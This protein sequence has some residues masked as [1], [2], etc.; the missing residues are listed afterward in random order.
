MAMTL[1]A[2][3]AAGVIGMQR[4]TIQ[5][6][7][8][9]RRFDM[10]TQ[11]RQRVGRA[12]PARRGVLDPAEL[13]EPE[14][15]RPQQD[16]LAQERRHVRRDFCN[17]PMPAAPA[18]GLSPAFD[19][20]GRDLPTG[21]TTRPSTACSTGSSGSRRP[22]SVPPTL[23][24]QAHRADA[25]RGPRVLGAARGSGD[26]QLRG[27]LRPRRSPRRRLSTWSTRRPQSGRRHA[28][29]R[30]RER[31]E[32][33]RPTRLHAG[34]AHGLARRGPHRDDRRRR[35]RP[36]RDDDLLRGGSPL[37]DRGER[38]LCGRA[39][40]PGPLA[41]R[42]HVDGKH[43]AR[44]QRQPGRPVRAEDLARAR[45]RRPPRVTARSPN[46]LQGIRIIVGGSLADRARART[47]CRATTASTPTRSR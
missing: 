10:A 23:P 21:I 32:S 31:G 33:R 37:G 6:G 42:V 15:H 17:I 47:S 35:A 43:P 24:A 30:D 45:A 5:G 4:V 29:E 26:R 19:T 27:R 18:D 36:H 14:H 13:A 8:D 41:R 20:F 34:R 44:A 25:R 28:D 11:H 38:P 1:F 7:E 3:G 9:A 12:P 46:N 16:A 22:A 39:P 40:S 2:I